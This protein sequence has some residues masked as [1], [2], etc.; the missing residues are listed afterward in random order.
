[1]FMPHAKAISSL[2]GVS[3]TMT[4]SFRGSGFLVHDGSDPSAAR[5]PACQMNMR[6]LL[7]H[8]LAVRR[9]LAAC[10]LVVFATL[11]TTDAVACPDG[12]Q[13]AGSPT[14][15]DRCNAT[16][17]CVFCTGGVIQLAEHTAIAPQ[18]VALPAPVFADQTPPI[19]SAAV[20]DHPPRLA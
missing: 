18:F 15:A 5:Q 4:V 13:S 7:M 17:N 8:N 14:G 11:A 3:V 1:M 2:S 12:C 19:L 6:S 16:G 10:L 20:L 9:L